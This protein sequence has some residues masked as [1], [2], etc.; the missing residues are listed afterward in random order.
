MQINSLTD[1]FIHGLSDIYSRKTV[2]L[3]HY[4]NLPANRLML[5][6]LMRLKTL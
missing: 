4:R 3:V 1:F 6:S 5:N 2:S